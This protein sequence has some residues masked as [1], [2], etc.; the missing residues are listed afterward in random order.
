MKIEMFWH[1]PGG[2]VA[3][4]PPFA[5]NPNDPHKDDEELQIAKAKTA[6]QAILHRQFGSAPPQ[7]QISVKVIED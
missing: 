7:D 2:A 4:L 5:V 3:A 1:Q 6:A